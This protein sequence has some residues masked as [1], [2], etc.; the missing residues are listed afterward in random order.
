M[1]T[2]ESAFAASVTLLSDCN[3]IW[4]NLEVISASVQTFPFHMTWCT[5][6]YHLSFITTVKGPVP[7][8]P[9]IPFLTWSKCFRKKGNTFLV[10]VFK[11]E[12]IQLIITSCVQNLRLSK[13]FQCLIFKNSQKQRLPKKDVS[14]W[15]LLVATVLQF[16]S[17]YCALK[18]HKFV[19]AS[20]HCNPVLKICWRGCDKLSSFCGAFSEKKRNSFDPQ[21]KI[22]RS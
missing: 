9:M 14:W 21:E 18:E 17:F 11:I 16:P 1:R 2:T 6:I 15:E 7:P 12:F 13:I 20:Q 5:P 3:T 22:E 4:V 19:V 10:L 8:H